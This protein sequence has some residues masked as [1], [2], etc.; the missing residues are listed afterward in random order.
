VSTEDLERFVVERMSKRIRLSSAV[1]EFAA[2][3]R[4]FETERLSRVLTLVHLP[5]AAISFHGLNGPDSSEAG[6]VFRTFR[7]G[8]RALLDARGVPTP[9]WAVFAPA[10]YKR[11]ERFAAGLGRPVL[12]RPA[13]LR[14]GTAGHVG[15]GG[16]AFR[17][18]WRRALEADDSRGGG[19]VLIEEDVPGERLHVFVVDGEMVAATQWRPRGSAAEPGTVQHTVRQDAPITGEPVDVTDEIQPRIATLAVDALRAVPGLPYGGVDLVVSGESGVGEAGTQRAVVTQVDPAP[20]PAAHFPAQ[21]RPRDVAGAILDHYLTAPRWRLARQ[22]S[23][24]TLA[25]HSA[26]AAEPLLRGQHR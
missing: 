11:A 16:D 23:H 14:R 6:R 18:A 22:T 24:R 1:L 15:A 17:T 21:G 25:V 5:D 20:T 12:V 9:A 19:P 26:E 13:R 3:E 10:Q 8:L 7:D 4:G 2:Q